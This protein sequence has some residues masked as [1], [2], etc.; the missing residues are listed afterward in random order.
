MYLIIQSLI[1]F[2]FIG[3]VQYFRVNIRL[4]YS[5][6][7]RPIKHY[8]VNADAIGSYEQMD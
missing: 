3:N 7:L 4:G 2:V 6:K 8:C 1:L 5:F